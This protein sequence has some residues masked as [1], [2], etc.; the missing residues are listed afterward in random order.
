[1]ER[2]HFLETRRTNTIP[3]K[4]FLGLEGLLCG[5]FVVLNLLGMEKLAIALVLA[6]LQLFIWALIVGNGLGVLCY[7][8]ALV[9]IGGAAFLPPS[10]QQFAF[11]PVVLLL[12]GLCYVAPWARCQVNFR[13]LSRIEK[14]PIVTLGMVII[15]SFINAY[16]KGWRGP[17]LLPTTV[18][19]LELLLI[20]YLCAKMEL[21]E[22]EITKVLRIIIFSTVISTLGVFALAWS[23]G[24]GS[25][26]GSKS[27][28][29]PFGWLNL[30]AWGC[31][32]AVAGIMAL[33][34]VLQG[35][36]FLDR[37]ILGVVIFILLA[38]LVLTK[39]RGAWLGFGLALLYVL[40]VS[41]S[42]KLI[43]VLAV[44][45][46]VLSFW[47]L[48]RQLVFTRFSETTLFDPSLAGR[49]LLWHY[50]WKIGK[51]NW[52]L[53]VGMENFR[54]VKHLY[55]FPGST[56]MGL[57]FNAHNIYLELF[58]DLGFFGAMAFL[59][60]LAVALVRSYATKFDDSL[61][62]DVRTVGI[63]LSAGIITFMVH[64]LVDA[65]TYN[66]GALSLLII[67]VGL[68]LAFGRLKEKY[69]T[70]SAA[71]RSAR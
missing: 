24:V 53:G 59:A 37:V 28:L 44:V 40:I 31:I 62:Y 27:V 57:P 43:L 71:E 35:K 21:D 5:G 64:G 32:A 3:L 4:W 39:S 36:S 11:Y 60:L 56:A 61:P 8:A 30:N 47:E 9:P 45:L 34:F 23:R 10:Y 63:A 66:P 42:F 13:T 18:L 70:V 51:I 49:F 1:M 25:D 55:R 19:M 68:S 50:A 33:V 2:S 38:M 26:F 58:A 15:L 46:F 67:L 6:P 69:R 17:T 48:A 20:G 14:I 65:F 54:F 29:T 16:N 22:S 41:R 7:F 52:L 12:L